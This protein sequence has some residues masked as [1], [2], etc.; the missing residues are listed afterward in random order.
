M[1]GEQNSKKPLTEQIISRIGIP[2]KVFLTGLSVPLLHDRLTVH[3][4]RQRQLF[5][6]LP[7]VLLPDPPEVPAGA[8]AAVAADL[9]VAAAEVVAAVAGKLFTCAD[10]HHIPLN[11]SPQITPGIVFFFNH[12]DDMKTCGL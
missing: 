4:K 1:P 10:D 12:F 6:A 3:L 11:S 5:P 9:P 2:G 7:P 8:L